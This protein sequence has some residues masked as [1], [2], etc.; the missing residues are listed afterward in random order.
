MSV[1]A[2]SIT[3]EFPTA[4]EAREFDA[5]AESLGMNASEYV[6]FLF[7]HRGEVAG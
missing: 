4:A 5:A 7:E 3:I 6:Q 2:D 1:S